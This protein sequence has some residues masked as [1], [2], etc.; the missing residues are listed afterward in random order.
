MTIFFSDIVGFTEMA[1]VS[2]PMEIV[3]FLNTLYGLFDSIIDQHDCYKVQL[4]ESNLNIH[5]TK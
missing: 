2:S 3:E 5:K 4:S 1:A